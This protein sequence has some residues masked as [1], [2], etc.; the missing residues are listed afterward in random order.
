MIRLVS[1]LAVLSIGCGAAT[2]VVQYGSIPESQHVEA[3]ELPESP[4]A[5]PI[6]RENDWVVALPASVCTDAKGVERKTLNGIILS[7]QKAA[8]AKRWQDSYKNLRSL[9]D[10][11]RQIWGQHRIIDEERMKQANKEI[12]RL[13]PSWWD[14]NKGTFGWGT[15][16]IAGAAAT[17][18]IVYA[19]DEVK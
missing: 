6:A 18:A 8:R 4:A 7:P 3:R 15:G 11:D 13:S 16:F 17:I 10:I 1:I 2:P 5:D 12:K 19:V 14:E 9:Y